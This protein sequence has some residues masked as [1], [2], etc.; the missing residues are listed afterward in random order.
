MIITID[1]DGS[2]VTHEFP[3]IG[4]N[5]GAE[6]VLRKLVDNGHKLILWT[7]RSDTVQGDYLTQAV[8]WF[9]KEQI[10]LFAINTNPLQKS[11]TTSPKCLADLYIGDD[12][13]GC[14]LLFNKNIS[15]R[16]FVD[17]EVIEQLL[18][19]QDII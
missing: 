1:F 14:P 16:R 6:K 3:L 15:E 2:C 9:E 18:T 5:I 13:L 19:A 4:M 17:W 7:M 8:K 12:A 11:W 10:K